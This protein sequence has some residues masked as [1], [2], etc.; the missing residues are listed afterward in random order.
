LECW[1]SIGLLS[2]L[3][4][5]EEAVEAVESWQ[6]GCSPTS[7]SLSSEDDADD[8]CA[9]V[10]DFARELW[11]C[12]HDSQVWLS[13]STADPLPASGAYRFS[14]AFDTFRVSVSSVMLSA[15]ALLE[16]AQTLASSADIEL[17]SADASPDSFRQ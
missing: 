6:M 15:R 9:F 13:F 10:V 14:S 1:Y 5:I 17:R 8:D 7:S 3:P 2:L 11:G 16:H 12:H 4:D